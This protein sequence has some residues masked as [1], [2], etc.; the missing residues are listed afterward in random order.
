MSY[1][2]MAHCGGFFDGADVHVYRVENNKLHLIRKDQV[3]AGGTHLSGWIP[4]LED[5]KVLSPES[6][7]AFFPLGTSESAARPILLYRACCWTRVATSRRLQ[8]RFAVETPSGAGRSNSNRSSGESE[9][10][11]LS[12]APAGP[13]PPKNLRGEV[14]RDELL[15]LKWDPVKRGELRGYVVSINQTTRQRSN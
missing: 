11:S 15:E 14:K 4:V 3:A 7:L 6:N 5:N 1:R 12:S 9:P 10:Q 2:N 13:L 8:P